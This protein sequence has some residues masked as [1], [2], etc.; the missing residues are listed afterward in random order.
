VAREW[1]RIGALG[2]GGPPAHVALLRD[3]TVERRR[4]IDPREF[5]D[6]FA[7]CNLLP[8]PASTQLSIYT[9][10]RV[11]GRWGAIVGGLAFIL[12]GLIVCLAIA[13]VALSKDPPPAVDAFGMGAAAAVVAVV[14]QAGLK[15]IDPRRGLPYVIA[16]ALGAALTGPYV[17][18]I[19]LVAGLFELSR[20]KL[21]SVAWP[22]LIW[23]AAKVGALSYGGGYVIIPLMYGDAVEAHGWMSE[24]AFAN[25]VAYGQITPGP[26]THTVAFVG[27]AAGGLGPALV[28]TAVAFAPSFAFILLGA[29]HFDRLRASPNAR[30]FLDGAGPAAAGAIL[31]A[32]VP[33]VTAIHA[34]WQWVVLAAAAIA[35][36]A[37]VP[38]LAVLVAGA[39]AGVGTTLV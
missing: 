30:A 31:G 26:V 2:F 38:P 32:A 27:Y 39:I 23:L 14:V 20:H 11:A 1:G 19:L 4:W 12:P 29:R 9:A 3:L 36:L 34:T 25:A 37:R 35:L 15:L 21:M 10:Q 5:E 16:G 6:A 28:A 18:V 33:L 8:G 22:A 7:A 17:V 13:A 24:Q